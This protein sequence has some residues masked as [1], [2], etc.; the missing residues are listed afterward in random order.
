MKYENSNFYNMVSKLYNYFEKI[1]GRFQEIS[2][3]IVTQDNFDH[4]IYILFSNF[5]FSLK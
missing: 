2:K 1:S 4:T 3:K 5:M